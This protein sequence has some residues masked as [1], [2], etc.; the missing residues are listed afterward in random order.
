MTSKN[1]RAGSQ[2]I[3]LSTSIPVIIEK[4][5]RKPQSTKSSNI[6]M[7]IE[8]TIFEEILQSPSYSRSSRYHHNLTEVIIGSNS[9]IPPTSTPLSHGTST[10]FQEIDKD[11][12]TKKI[13][14]NQSKPQRRT[15]LTISNTLSASIP[16]PQP[17]QQSKPF[18]STTSIS[19]PKI[20][21]NAI[22]SSQL[23][24]HSISGTIAGIPN[25]IHVSIARLGRQYAQYKLMGG[26]SRCKAMLYAFLDVIQD[27][28][29]PPNTILN[30]HLDTH[31]K[32]QINYLVTCRPLSTSM[33]NAI[34]FIKCQI[35]NLPPDIPEQEAKLILRE[36][37]LSFIHERIVAADQLI[38][39]H[40]TSKIQ[41]NDVILV[42]SKSDVVLTS[43][44][45]A[46]NQGKRF[47]VIVV[48]SRPWLEGKLSLEYLVKCGIPVTYIL[49]NAIGYIIN[50]VTKIILG[51]HCVYS[52]GTVQSRAGTCIIA[53]T[54]YN[55]KVPVIVCCEMYKFSDRVQLD[56]SYSC[57]YVTDAK[58]LQVSKKQVKMSCT[59]Y[60][61][62]P[63]KL[64]NMIISEIGMIP[65]TSVPVVIREYRSFNM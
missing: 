7:D 19:Q 6:S 31:L 32:P 12:K 27:Y 30:R 16:A 45:K 63:S 64:I 4:Q 49:I 61:I 41:D 20:D 57:E 15:S 36:D 51:A 1:D 9:E 46:Y 26:N 54:G 11:H 8:D 55:Y 14:N 5:I 13:T 58:S 2:N 3:P 38:A 47:R 48:D 10:Q 56:S 39:T 59:M 52:N 40:C 33:G 28:T 50:Q 62:T 23:P 29:T 60:D 34:R 18:I 22:H 43:L 25:N 35:A 53:M 37:I 24:S 21:A 44:H 42:Y 65:C 17:H